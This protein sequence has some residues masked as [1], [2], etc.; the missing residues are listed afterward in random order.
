MY[1]DAVREPIV[2]EADN[3]NDRPALNA[4]LSIRG[5]TNCGMLD[6]YVIDTD[7][8]SFASCTVDAVLCSAEQEK[9]GTQQLLRKDVL[10]LLPL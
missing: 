9:K 4:D 3:A 1:K 8:Q 7:A 10:H 6:V 5:A 2:Q